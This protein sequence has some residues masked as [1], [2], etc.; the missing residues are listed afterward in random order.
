MC[1]VYLKDLYIEIFFLIFILREIESEGK[2][3]TS[4]NSK[5]MRIKKFFYIEIKSKH[6]VLERETSS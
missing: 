5:K 6:A 3:E 2:N 1:V 4:V